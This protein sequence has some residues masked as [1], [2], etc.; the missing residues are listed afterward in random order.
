MGMP[1]IVEL[2][3]VRLDEVFVRSSV[4][5]RKPFSR[6]SL[7]ADEDVFDAFVAKPVTTGATAGLQYIICS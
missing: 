5:R 1:S 3:Y 2:S 6:T 7:A 4:A